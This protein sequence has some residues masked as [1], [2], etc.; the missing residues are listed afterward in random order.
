MAN[1]IEIVIKASNRAKPELTEAERQAKKMA[2]EQ[3]QAAKQAA[4]AQETAA[5]DAKEAWQKFAAGPKKAEESVRHLGVGGMAMGT[6]IGGAALGAGT[7][8]LGMAKDAVTGAFQTIASNEQAE[9]SF[10]TLTGSEKAAKQEMAVLKDF[11]AKTPFELPG[12]IQDAKLLQGVGMEFKNVIPTMTAWGDAAG[13]LGVSQDGFQR[14]MLALSQSISATKINAGD[15]NQIVEAG[16]PIWKIMAEALGKPVSE[17]RKMSEKGELLTADVLPKLNAQM[18]KD[19]G[20]NMA[21]QSQT[22]SGMWSTLMD[23]FHQGMAD[24]LTPLLPI[25]RD[26]MPGAMKMTGSALKGLADFLSGTIRIFQRTSAEART[27]GTFLNSLGNIVK[28][29]ASWV[30]DSLIPAFQRAASSVMPA[31][32]SAIKTVTDA[33]RNNQD[34]VQKVRGIFQALGVIITQAVI[35]TLAYVAK[36][37]LPVLANTFSGLI[38]IMNRVVLPG[39]KLFVNVVLGIFGFII[40]GAAQAFGWIPGIGPRLKRAA[41]EFNSFRN[42]VNSALSGIRS[43]TVTVNI[44]T[45]INGHVANITSGGNLG[46][47]VNISTGGH[48]TKARR[49]GG[50]QGAAG[51]GPRSNT[52][53]VGED[54]PELIELPGGSSVH[55][56]PDTARMLGGGWGQPQ[57][58][59]LEVRSS[60]APVD[61]FLAELIRRYVRIR[62]GNVQAVFGRGA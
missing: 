39:L 61:D 28:G 12:L 38:T 24:A 31:V 26:V 55:S 4:R 7:A 59:V 15:M 58:V 60:G 11:A 25:L 8:L 30:R 47:V 41:A 45:K 5:K 35:P 40:N 1:E 44:V 18:S 56:A 34:M 52:T 36:T 17:I 43:R 51:G 42:S 2:R 57:R 23:T 22:L 10:A 62:G 50:I 20:G 53:L 19:Y 49:T 48:T 33:F 21:K 46:D 29:V 3:E 37:A 13:A 9:I 54:G 14:T 27:S 6:M 32:H 16:I